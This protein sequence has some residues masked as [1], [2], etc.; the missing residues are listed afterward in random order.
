VAHL[1]S[2]YLHLLTFFS[3]LPKSITDL[4]VYFTVVALQAF[5]TNTPRVNPETGL[6]Q[7]SETQI[8]SY[9]RHL[10][11]D[12]GFRT[13]GTAG[14]AIADKWM[15]DTAHE[16]EKERQQLA[17]ADPERKLECEVWHQRGSGAHR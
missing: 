15:V 17:E 6:P 2:V 1:F 4:C 3:D 12:I 7:I 10:S 8:L 13:V 5:L 16:V 11:E 14:H 9:V